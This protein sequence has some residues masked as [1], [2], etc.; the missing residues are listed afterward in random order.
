MTSGGAIIDA[1]T[2]LREQGATINHVLC[3]IDRESTGRE[4][5]EELGLTF[6]PL[7]TKSDLESSN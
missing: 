3:V 2:K 4:N 7:F 5:L 1:V 6:T